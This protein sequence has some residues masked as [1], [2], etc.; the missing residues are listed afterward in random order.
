MEELEF[1]LQEYV[2]T[3][4]DPKYNG[5]YSVINSKFPE[6]ADI[7]PFVL[8]EYVLTA[9]DPKHGGDWGV[10]NSK[11]PEFET[12]K[13]SSSEKVDDPLTKD[14]DESLSYEGFLAQQ[15]IKNEERQQ[16]T[17]EQWK[18]ANPEAGKDSEG[19]MDLLWDKV[20]IAPSPLSITAL[21][22]KGD[23]EWQDVTDAFSVA[24]NAVGMVLDM[25]PV[26]DPT[27]VNE[28][29]DRD[30]R[31]RKKKERSAANKAY[32]TWKNEFNPDFTPSNIIDPEKLKEV[33]LDPT[34][35]IGDDGE[36]Y[37]MTNADDT[38]SLAGI[39]HGDL[40]T[41]FGEDLSGDEA[42]RFAIWYL[43]SDEAKQHREEEKLVKKY[44]GGRKRRYEHYL[45]VAQLLFNPQGR[46]KEDKKSAYEQRFKS[47]IISAYINYK[48]GKFNND[49]DIYKKNGI[50]ELVDDLNLFEN[51]TKVL[52][53]ERD[54]KIKE[55]E[56]MYSKFN[57]GSLE[58]NKDNI[59]TFNDLRIDVLNLDKNYESLLKSANI[60]L[61]PHTRKLLDGYFKL[62]G[63]ASF[64]KTLQ[65]K[66][67]NETEFGKKLN[68][69]LDDQKA[70]DE[71]Y[72]KW[73]LGG[74]TES[75]PTA[76][77]TVVNYFGG[78]A[79]V[80]ETAKANLMAGLDPENKERYH[81]EAFLF[82]K[83]IEVDLPNMPT[84]ST[85]F[86][87]P[88][89]GEWNLSKLLPSVTKTVGDMFMM[90]RGS[91]VSYKTLTSVG[92]L[93]NKGL[94]KTGVQPKNLKGA[95]DFYK[96]SASL[97]SIGV[98]SL[99]VLL[100]QNMSQAF[101][102]IDENF[103]IEDAMDY[104]IKTTFVEAAIEVVNPDFRMIKRSVSSIK[105]GLKD[106]KSLLKTLEN[107]RL[108]ALK[109]AFGDVP[110]EL[111]EEYLQLFSNRF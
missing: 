99:P 27:K 14:V 41:L 58:Q 22:F 37:S 72:E 42:V 67:L 35:Y 74:V 88:E 100:P 76:V 8:Q 59:N 102:A 96:K 9:N 57:N 83:A 46:K 111:L 45:D 13:Y 101:A 31:A 66:F 29:W 40:K 55:L 43:G 50:P 53:Q 48:H 54:T 105:K 97:S 7:D 32:E 93:T 81:T 107:E 23:I 77:N 86:V 56:E 16:V 21:T 52:I 65:M 24:K 51:D 18:T 110:K 28:R 69:E 26:G 33:E 108:I 3:A 68:E 4:N 71:W 60:V 1:A 109:A 90:S 25:M 104:S 94:L 73:G 64:N 61:S 12:N 95:G 85:S 89:T 5:D 6:L 30:I 92:N 39:S 47:N 84:A 62:S 79:T 44:D 10:I 63:D 36:V 103:T 38:W 20:K 70:T 82:N 34:K 15:K 17:L 80:L 75:A 98:G 78:A 2:L 11:F 106:P 91:G 49:L 87:D 19:F